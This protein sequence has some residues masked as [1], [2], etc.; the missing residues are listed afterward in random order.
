MKLPKLLTFFMLPVIS[1]TG[2]LFSQ[3]DFT[4]IQTFIDSNITRNFINTN[5][6]NNRNN[7]ALISK[8]NF[9]KDIG[10]FDFFLKNYYSS[11]VTKLNENLYRDFDNI[12]TGV[13]YN[14]NDNLN[15]SGNFLGQFFSDDRTFQ[16][17]G[18][19]SNMAYISSLYEALW[20]GSQVYSVL[21]AGYKVESQFE[22]LDKGPSF[23]GDFNIYNLNLSDFLIDGK[24]KLGYESLDPRKKNMAYTHLY[25]ARPFE[26]NLARNEF[27]GI[28]SRI[29]KDFYFPADQNSKQQF[30]INSNIEK[31]VETIFRV[32]NRFDYTISKNIALVFNLSPNY[33][34][35]TKE[36]EYI[37]VTPTLQP[38]IYD[39]D[40]QELSLSGD[41]ALNFQLKKVDFQVKAYYSE[42]D[43]KHFLINS[44]RVTSNF[45]RI[46]EE[47][48]A[49]KNNHSSIFKLNTNVYYNVNLMNRFEF[50]G[51]ASV[52][53]YDT[54]SRINYDDRD[55]LGFLVYFAHR[56][57]NL[58]NLVLVTSVDL[59]LYHTV[60]IFSQRSSNNNW[61]RV[62]RFTSKSF[63]EPGENFRNVGT[64]SVLANYTV[65]DFQDVVSSV[66]SF[67]FR[68]VSLK[69][70]MIVKFSKHFG[71][72][73]YGEI[74]FYERGELNWSE[75]TQRPVNYFEDKIINSELNYFFNKF[76][77]I[78]AGY[79]FFEQRRYNYIAGERV[80]ENFVR[81]TGPFAALK[82]LWKRN[83]TIEILTS[84]DYYKYGDENPSTENSNIQIN[85]NWNF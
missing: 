52:L 80:F 55:E 39:T 61:N 41:I 77:T 72:D 48:E 60:Y 23:S 14:V 51:Y 8:V 67:S 31:R 45:V 7:A 42:R 20:G 24:L 46:I 2:N 75:F 83:S 26:N 64:F 81:T 63:F 18:S 33:R 5:F 68:Q 57:N 78:S 73:I 85:A 13:G 11:S 27:D 79:R 50:S 16:L 40:I 1:F 65:Y 62:L 34:R 38:S 21:N 22:E 3:S 36:N 47:N 71:T 30:G 53:K 74:K 58:S 29:R 9:Y 37:P 17:K 84:Y 59:N 66:R 82:V 6:D 19:S 4:D 54:Q 70:S 76:V 25:I 69:D 28:F 44:S 15:I 35:V 43:E 56:F 32:Y 10:K 49:T 12:K